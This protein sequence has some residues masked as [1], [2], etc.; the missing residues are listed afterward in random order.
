[1]VKNIKPAS[2]A[3]KTLVQP[4]RVRANTIK[5]SVRTIDGPVVEFSDLRD[6]DLTGNPNKPAPGD[7]GAT[8][9]NAICA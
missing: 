2:A 5:D 3:A 8:T 7:K 9:A 4:A 6:D 1:M